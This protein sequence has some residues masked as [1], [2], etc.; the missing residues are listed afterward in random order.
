MRGINI[1]YHA[2][3]LR[4]FRDVALKG[5]TSIAGSLSNL[6][7]LWPR[8]IGGWGL[9]E[10]MSRNFQEV[11]SR[12]QSGWKRPSPRYLAQKA[13][14]GL[15]PLTMVRTRRLYDSLTAPGGSA[16]SIQ[17]GDARN[18]YY[19]VNAEAFRQHGHSYPEIHQFRGDSTG[20]V[21]PFM[22][23]TQPTVDRVNSW[24]GQNI[25]ARLREIHGALRMRGAR[26]T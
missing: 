4:K 21:R 23:F 16:D 26:V 1:K 13:K 3:P 15:S 2:E 18:Y 24:I 22:W 10:I 20:T 6:T 12:G 5:Q 19:G 11:W 25:R 9:P 14:R 8:K 17:F 7:W